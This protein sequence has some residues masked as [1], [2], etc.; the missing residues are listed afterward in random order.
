MFSRLSRRV[1][2]NS[3]NNGIQ[4]HV[5]SGH[6]N[7]M[8]AQIK[9]DTP[10]NVE[11]NNHNKHSK[12]KLDTPNVNGLNR[13]DDGSKAHEIAKHYYAILELLGENPLR[14]GL[15]KTPM[16]AAKALEYLTHGYDLNIT[17]LMNNAIFNENIKDKEIVIVKNINFYSLCEHHLLPFHGSV[18]IGYLPE[19]KI[20]GLSKLA[21]IV[22]M[23]SRRL[24]VQE[25]MTIEISNEINK[26]LSPFGVAVI[27]EA[28]HMCMSMRGVQK[29]HSSTI[30]SSFIGTF[31]NDNETRKEFLSLINK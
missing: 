22:E 2:L 20:V 7:S 15:I 3:I 30:T 4:Q 1:G 29:E 21:R 17:K 19:N 27:V 18:T 13:L 14:E 9:R 5:V 25:R 23:Y 6:R 8:M 12:N 10:L 26:Q 24:Q 11:K 28:E 31:K 16:R